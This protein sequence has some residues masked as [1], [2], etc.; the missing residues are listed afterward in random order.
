MPSFYRSHICNM[1]LHTFTMLAS[2]NINL[3]VGDVASVFEV[4]SGSSSSC[5]MLCLGFSL[6]G[7]GPGEFV[8]LSTWSCCFSLTF[9]SSKSCSFACSSA[10]FTTCSFTLVLKDNRSGS[11]RFDFVLFSFRRLTFDLEPV[12]S[13][14]EDD[15]DF[16]SSGSFPSKLPVVVSFIRLMSEDPLLKL[17]DA[18]SSKR[19]SSKVCD[20]L[21]KSRIL[22]SLE[23]SLERATNVG[24]A[25]FMVSPLSRRIPVAAGTPSIKCPTISSSC[26]SSLS[27]MWCRFFALMCNPFVMS[28]ASRRN[29]RRFC[30]SSSFSGRI[31]AGRF[32][33]TQGIRTRIW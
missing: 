28:K 8:G 33:S 10:I 17:F 1:P 3:L 6:P 16:S 27:R 29:N 11:R 24:A 31:R 25:I 32:L 20:L 22:C 14:F 19:L 4:S 5:P 21:F 15:P 23:M 7:D 30:S 9:S 13:P 2:A 12:P 26:G 18:V